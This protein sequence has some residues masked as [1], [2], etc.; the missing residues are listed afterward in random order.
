MNS[1][2]GLYIVIL[3]FVVVVVFFVAFRLQFK[4]GYYE[5]KLINHDIKDSV[6]DMSWWKMWMN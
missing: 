4:V 1:I 2:L 3:A 5:Q 6:K